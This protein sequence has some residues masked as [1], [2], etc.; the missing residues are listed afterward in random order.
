MT[1]PAA[2]RAGYEWAYDRGPF[3][4]MDA[5]DACEAAGYD[6]DDVVNGELWS[7][8]AEAAQN[9]QIEDLSL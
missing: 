9:E 1:M 8:G 4:G 5:S 2:W 7:A 3:A 6:L